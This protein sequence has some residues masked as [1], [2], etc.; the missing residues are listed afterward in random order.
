MVTAISSRKP[1]LDEWN[2]RSSSVRDGKRKLLL[3]ARARIGIQILTLHGR[4]LVIERKLD[5]CVGHSVWL[6]H[7]P[8]LCEFAVVELLGQYTGSRPGVQEGQLLEYAGYRWQSRS[9]WFAM[10]RAFSAWAHARESRIDPTFL[11]WYASSWYINY[12]VNFPFVDVWLGPHSRLSYTTE[13]VTTS[14]TTT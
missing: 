13:H 12:I 4:H 9:E 11:F 10:L 1:L 14:T 5:Q 2:V 8:T 6:V 7:G 3:L